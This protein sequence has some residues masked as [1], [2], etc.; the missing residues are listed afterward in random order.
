MVEAFPYRQVP[1][2][3]V[4]DSVTEST[5]AVRYKMAAKIR[6]YPDPATTASCLH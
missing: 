3:S 2:R 6:S 4:S 5:T 1:A